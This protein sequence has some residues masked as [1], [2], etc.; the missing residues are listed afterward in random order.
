MKLEDITSSASRATREGFGAG[1]L[2]LGHKNPDVVGLT[3]DLMES[4]QMQ[5]FQKEKCLHLQSENQTQVL[6]GR[7]RLYA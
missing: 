5:H 7:G 2:E 3:A 1:L 4:L 6:Y